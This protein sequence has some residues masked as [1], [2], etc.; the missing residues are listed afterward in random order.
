[1]SIGKELQQARKRQGWSRRH[2]AQLLHVTQ[3]TVFR[4][5]HEESAV[6]FKRLQQLVKVLPGA[7]LH[8]TCRECGAS[9]CA[10]GEE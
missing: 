2:L 6:P 9:H 5:E 7:R 1:M 8:W 10:G 3:L 4:W